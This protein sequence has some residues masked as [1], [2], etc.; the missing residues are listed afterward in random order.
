MIG[1]GH[2][3]RCLALAA[4]LRERG[5]SVCF[6]CR[7]RSGDLADDIAAR[8]FEVAKLPART[9][10]DSGADPYASWLG[11]SWTDDADETLRVIDK[12]GW[13]PSWLIVDHYGTDHRWEA[14]LRPAVER[15]M[16]IDDLANRDHDC[17]LLLDQN[18]VAEQEERYSGR[19]PATCTTL[20]GPGFALLQPEYSEL[21]PRMP[22]R[23]GPI[24]RILLYFGG[25]DRNGLTQRALAA[26]C[27]PCTPDVAVDVILASNQPVNAHVSAGAGVAVTFH[28]QVE[29]LAP[30]IA[31]A[32]LC[33]GAGGA[34]S[35]ERLCLGLPAIV[36]TR[37][38]NQ[39]PI[40]A[41]L[42]RRELVNWLGDEE[43][44]DAGLIGR[45]VQAL[46]ESG[47]DGTWSERCL[48]FVDGQGAGRVCDV[49]LTGATDGFH[50]RHAHPVDEQQLLAWA[51]DP[52]T[53]RSGFW[54]DRITPEG[55]HRWFDQRLRNVDGCHLYIVETRRGSAVGQVRFESSG[56]EWE[57]HYA[58]GPAFRGRGIGRELLRTALQQLR[59][60]V[61]PVVVRGLVKAANK[62]SA[63][64]FESLGF[65]SVPVERADFV[66]YRGHC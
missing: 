66:E 30:L 38:Q 2:V 13:R 51:N 42:H 53:R 16:V 41:E 64:I 8:G 26:V 12:L 48:G 29:S 47:L 28:H 58:V 10:V 4:A 25:D 5:E 46:I 23:A 6:V 39:R 55:H 7:Q 3:M 56:D 22:P 34:T 60:D 9:V 59:C 36:I 24:R 11:A 21:H 20:L 43:Q 17:D 14:A 49:M 52:V 19:L 40:A 15:I 57:V 44:V 62:R 33:V 45:A 35:W 37:A 65:E 54:A 18:L 63:S 32:D 1:S 31:R 27:R 50:A 61:G